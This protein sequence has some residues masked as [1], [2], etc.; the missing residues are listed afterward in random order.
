MKPDLSTEAKCRE[1]LDRYPDN[2]YLKER[3]ADILRSQG[4]E[5]QADAIMSAIIPGNTIKYGRGLLRYDEA[6]R[7]NPLD[8]VTLLNRVIWHH[9]HGV[10]EKA[11]ADFDRAI[12]IEPTI[13]YAFCSRA[14]L[15]ATCPDDRFRDGP[16]ALE[17]A[18]TALK[19]AEEHGELIGDWR[20]R[21]Y[22]QVLAAAHAENGSFQE[23]IK[24]QT[25]ALDLS[26]TKSSRHEITEILVVY[27][28]RTPYRSKS[29][30]IRC[31]FNKPT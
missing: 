26:I 22:L 3:L 18:V 10:W 30:L 19:L 31:G 5:D 16:K 7:R 21:Q 2:D 15:S 29:G 11:R 1:L 24:V 25:E 4:Q 23:A 8:A 20:Q 17:N 27:Q 12:E 14:S 28:D 13:A 9:W 6:I